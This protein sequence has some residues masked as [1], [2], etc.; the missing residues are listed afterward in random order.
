[1]KRASMSQINLCYLL[2]EQTKLWLFK[3][4]EDIKKVSEFYYY[5]SKY[6]SSVKL[7]LVSNVKL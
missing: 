6:V 2:H 5:Q 1:M 4:G 3:W 7:P